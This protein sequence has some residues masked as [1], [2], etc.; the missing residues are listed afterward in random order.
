MTA[1]RTQGLDLFP[2]HVEVFDFDD[3][4]ELN[5]ALLHAARTDSSL[6][7]STSGKSVLARD[8]AWVVDLRRRFDVA[9]S[10]YL[11]NVD[12]G[13][14]DPFELESYVFFNYTDGSSF[15]P[16]HDHLVEADLVAIYYAHA[17][18]REERSASSYYDLDDGILVLHDPR[19]EARVDRRGV[20]SRD[21]YRI[22]PRTNRLVVHPAGIRH[23]VTPSRGCER[24]AVT[25]TV[26]VDRSRLFEGYVRH[27]LRGAHE[28]R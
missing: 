18:V 1:P 27:R 23:S 19:V 11:A 15:T 26:T 8:D 12:P 20:A 5:H 3:A 28:D 13:H 14:E 4:P 6:R 21:H 7:S 10:T 2:V 24:L 22:Y 9:L 16:V 25:C 17:P